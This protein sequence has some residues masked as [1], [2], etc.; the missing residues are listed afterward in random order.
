[1][2]DTIDSRSAGYR[3]GDRLMLG[4]TGLLFVLSLALAGWYDTWFEA[5]LIGLPALVVPAVLSRVAPG[6][7]ITRVTFAL[8]LMVF[9][10]LHIQQAHGMIE[11]HFGIFVLLAFLLVY[12]DPWPILAGAGLIAAHHLGFDYLQASGA[13]VWVFE[14]RSGFGIVLVH[15]GYVVAE[16]AVLVWIARELAQESNQA[17]NMFDA[18]NQLTADGHIDL[19]ARVAGDEQSELAVRFNGFLEGL[20]QTMQE[21]RSASGH[22]TDAA[23]RLRQIASETVRGAETQQMSSTQAAT[24]MN[25][26]AHSASEVSANAQAALQAAMQ[27]AQRASDGSSVVGASSQATDALAA[28]M[29]SASQSVATLTADSQSVGTVL[30]VI[31]AIAEQTNLLALNA[32]IEAARAGE[33]GRGFA[34]V[35]DEVRTLAS[36]TQSSTEE[37]RNIIERLQSGAGQVAANM[38]QSNDIATDAKQRSEQAASTLQQILDA[39]QSMQ[40]LNQQIAA[41]TE[42]QNIAVAEINENITRISDIAAETSSGAHETNRAAEDMTAAAAALGQAVARFRG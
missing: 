34:V 42:Q 32:A 40:G 4:V 3:R 37:I 13:P 24:A 12:R 7:R 27:A 18:L 28:R 22:L 25:E 16:T 21:A 26:V 39:V 2:T 1:M 30:E 41:A 14:I 10:A 5:L 8:A 35:A 9:A 20:Q 36:R 31:Q 23:A 38:A 19:S 17:H 29:E 11:V 15:A 33:Q 6:Q